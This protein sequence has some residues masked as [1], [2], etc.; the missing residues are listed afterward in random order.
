M[1]MSP[2][3]WRLL[4]NTPWI[5]I[6]TGFASTTPKLLQLQWMV[7][8]RHCQCCLRESPCSTP[9]WLASPASDERSLPSPVLVHP[10]GTVMLACVSVCLFK[11]TAHKDLTFKIHIPLTH[12]PHSQILG[13]LLTIAFMYQ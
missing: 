6:H 10:I 12:F 1:T 2:N 4:A 13:E 9:L 7:F 8:T 5:Y 11:M 3:T